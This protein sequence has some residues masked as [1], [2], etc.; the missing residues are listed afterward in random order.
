MADTVS[1][2][3]SLW[4]FLKTPSKKNETVQEKDVCSSCGSDNLEMNDKEFICKD[5]GTINVSPLDCNAEW[6]WW[7]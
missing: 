2:N 4:D 7:P 6:R 5:C 3:E 1:I